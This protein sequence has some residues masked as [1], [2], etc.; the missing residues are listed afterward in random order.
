MED[1]GVDVTNTFNLRI[2]KRYQKRRV[3]Y[4]ERHLVAFPIVTTQAQYITKRVAF[5]PFA[6][7]DRAQLPDNLG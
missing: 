2:Q 6:A 1:S 4:Y 3:E 7:F 5:V